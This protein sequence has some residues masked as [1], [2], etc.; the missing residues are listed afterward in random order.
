MQCNC[1]FCRVHIDPP[2]LPIPV[3]LELV[4]NDIQHILVWAWL[5]RLEEDAIEFHATDVDDQGTVVSH[6]VHS[7]YELVRHFA[8]RWNVEVPEYHMPSMAKRIFAACGPR[9]KK[10]KIPSLRQIIPPGRGAPPT[11]L[12]TSCRC[13]DGVKPTSRVTRMVTRPQIAC[14]DGDVSEEDDDEEHPDLAYDPATLGGHPTRVKELLYIRERWDSEVIEELLKE[15]AKVP[16]HCAHKMYAK[17]QVR[18]VQCTFIDPKG[19]FVRDVWIPFGFLKCFY[20]TQ[21][22]HLS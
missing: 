5:V 13:F 18:R 9:R 1:V 20:P 2:A 19:R 17:K 7:E 16:L 8:S 4:L 12:G 11:D 14:S 10:T 21:V 3:R 22:A 6:A 15:G